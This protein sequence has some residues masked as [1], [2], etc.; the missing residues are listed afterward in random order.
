MCDA[1]IICDIPSDIAY[2]DQSVSTGIL[3]KT[4]KD[5]KMVPC[6]FLQYNTQILEETMVDVN[7]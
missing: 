4:D 7:F 3:Y 1:D 6:P 5:F 2:T